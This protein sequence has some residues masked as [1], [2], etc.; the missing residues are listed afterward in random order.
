MVPQR[1]FG[2]QKYVIFEKN[3][4]IMKF[5]ALVLLIICWTSISSQ[6]SKDPYQI[7]KQEMEKKEAKEAMANSIY[8][9]HSTSSLARFSSLGHGTITTFD[10]RYEGVVGS[11]YLYDDWQKGAVLIAGI[12]EALPVMLN[13]DCVNDQLLVRMDDGLPS[14]LPA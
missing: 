7:L 5:S 1:T 10:T 8:W 12:S 2:K 11:A 13:Y 14:S 9:Q 3:F 4:R 6:V